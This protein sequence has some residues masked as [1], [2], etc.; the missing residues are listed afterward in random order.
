VGLRVNDW[1]EGRFFDWRFGLSLGGDEECAYWG[2]CVK[3]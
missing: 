1:I 3:V 2:K